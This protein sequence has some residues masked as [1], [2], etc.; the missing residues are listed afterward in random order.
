MIRWLMMKLFRLSNDWL[1]NHPRKRREDAYAHPIAV[2]GRG[3]DY[4]AD[5][6][7]LANA[8]H[9]ADRTSFTIYKVSNGFVI[10]STQHIENSSKHSTNTVSNINFKICTT[11]DEVFD[12]IKQIL[13][14]NSLTR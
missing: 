9:P 6:V 7:E 2:G 1:E 5:E 10:A 12:H 8:L 3:H 11:G 14:L 4:V 13:V